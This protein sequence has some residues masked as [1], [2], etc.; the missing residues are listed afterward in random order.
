M[1]S[2]GNS[3]QQLTDSFVNYL[4]EPSHTRDRLQH[5]RSTDIVSRDHSAAKLSQT[6][7][8]PKLKNQPRM[9]IKS[10]TR[11][12]KHEIHSIDEE[13]AELQDTIYQVQHSQQQFRPSR[14][15][16]RHEMSVRELQ[17]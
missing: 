11:L 12:L 5:S 2:Q 14:E 4:Q 17:D 8:Q 7:S 9:N 16:S 13:I 6:A 1:M 10:N 3:R 15:E